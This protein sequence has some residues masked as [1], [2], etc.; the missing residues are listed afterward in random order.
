[1]RAGRAIGVVERR[2]VLAVL[3]GAAV[4]TA[5]YWLVWFSGGHDLLAS[6][7]TGA[8][9]DFENAFPLADSWFVV[10]L[11]AAATQLVRRRP[12]ALLWLL[13]AG[14]SALYLAA[15]DVLYDLEHGI[16]FDGRAGGVVEL[17]INV[18]TV[19]AG[20]GLLIWAWHQREALLAGS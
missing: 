10:C 13:A 2:V 12:S 5:T 17:A 8:Y 20:S 9:D 14:A 15:M 16:W 1:M 19:A 6:A 4:L 7:T 3:L 11:L 18:A